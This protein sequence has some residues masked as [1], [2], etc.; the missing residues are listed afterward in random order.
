MGFLNIVKKPLPAAA[1]PTGPIA[2]A[3]DS[4][5]PSKAAGQGAQAAP[6]GPAKGGSP[7]PGAGRRVR[8]QKRPRR[9]NIGRMLREKMG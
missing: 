5:A 2:G 6:A 9:G 4:P 7:A 8:G 3:A 1:T